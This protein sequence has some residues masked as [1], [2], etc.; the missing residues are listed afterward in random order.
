MEGVESVDCF[1]LAEDRE[2]LRVLVKTAILKFLNVLIFSLKNST[3]IKARS[4]ACS[5]L[6]LIVKLK[7][8]INRYNS[9][10]ASYQIEAIVDHCLSTHHN[11]SAVDSHVWME[12]TR[13]LCSRV[14]F[15]FLCFCIKTAS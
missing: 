6:V 12:E 13:F 15:P 1:C 9:G 8:K 3:S 10:S 2:Q 14:I 7:L 11:H 4:G 5:N